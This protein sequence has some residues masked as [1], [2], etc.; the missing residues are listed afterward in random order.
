II[1][2]IFYCP[3]ALWLFLYGINNY[4]MVYLFLR[5]VK[6]ES[7]VNQEFIKRFWSDHDKV[8][9][10]KVTTQLPV[11]NER[12]VVERLI[13]AVV[14][15]DYPKELHEIQVLDDSNDE[16]K[17]LVSDLVNKYRDMGFNI[18][19]V[20]RKN[21][22]GFK[23]GAL[24]LGLEEAEGEFLSIFDADFVPDKNFLYET[25]PFFYE[26]PNVALVQTRWGHIN[27]NYSLL[28]IAQSIGMDGHFIIEQGARAW[29][30]LYMNFNGTAGL[31]RR[32]AIIDAGG[33]HFDTLTEDLDLSYRVQLKGWHTKFLFDVVAPSELPI[34]I[35]AYKSQQ[36]RWA[37]GSIQ[38]AKKVLPQ[39]FK[40][41]DSVIK[42]IEAFIHLNQYMVHPM[43][44]I[45]ALFSFPLIIL[46]RA[47][48]SN[49]PVS[50][51]MITLLLLIFLGASAPSVL[52]VV[53]LKTGYKDW[54]KKCLFIP[55]L[56]VIGCGIAVNNTKAVLE[57][58]LN[59]KSD[60]IRTPK[61]GVVRRGKNIL[62]KSYSL[63]VA[64]FFISEI[65]LSAY[66]FIGFMQYT[67]NKK[68][69]FGPFLLMYAIGFF[70]VGTL[71]LFQ[72]L[73][74]RIKY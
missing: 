37:K 47:Q 54:R 28:T 41:N 66:C 21:R 48:I 30:G 9:L 18:K 51:T 27:R 19:H 20:V 62:A 11:Y 40:T 46:L 7:S 5:K 49:M 38:T 24:N 74:E 65:L 3:A 26:K 25:I 14:N 39:V 36:H 60:F 16:T 23:A 29:N 56:M 17:N 31:W 50:I 70:Y 72:K 10:P 64:T 35:T 57:A 15:I 55:T 4:Y 6:R 63:P 73:N 71:S 61:Y 44:I 53:A 69:V 34:D 32:E 8:R 12:H 45:L 33:W 13:N 58:L 22:K 42:K 68:F 59:I 67:S 1:I 43:M 2:L 52:Y